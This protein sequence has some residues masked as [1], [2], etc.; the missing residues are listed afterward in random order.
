[1]AG[2]AERR[3]T[4]RPRMSE[5]TAEGALQRTR[6]NGA[7][8]AVWTYLAVVLVYHRTFTSLFESPALQNWAT[9]LVSLTLQALPFLV[10]GVTVSAAISS[11]VPASWLAAALP[12]RP[13][14]AIPIAGI[15]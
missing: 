14:Y 2:A 15:A 12:S 6:G 8:I 11:L 13:R 5:A 3:P 1:M 9:I 4:L 7:T 10:L